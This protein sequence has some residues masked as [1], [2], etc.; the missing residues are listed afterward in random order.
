MHVLS[1]KLA[2]TPPVSSRYRKHSH[3][4]EPATLHPHRSKKHL[5]FSTRIVFRI[6][7]KFL[8]LIFLR[9][10][11]PLIPGQWQVLVS[12]KPLD[13]AYGNETQL[14]GPARWYLQF[15]NCASLWWSAGKIT[16]N[17]VSPKLDSMA[18]GISNMLIRPHR[19]IQPPHSPS[20]AILRR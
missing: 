4:N 12:E 20:I 8:P 3:L 16:L 9:H 13:P 14:H 17:P 15:L 2:K 19:A 6:W 5:V 10:T 1:S 7:N 18:P 11:F